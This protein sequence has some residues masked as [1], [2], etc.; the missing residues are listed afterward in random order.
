MCC[1]LFLHRMNNLVTFVLYAYSL[2]SVEHNWNCLDFLDMFQTWRRT[3]EHKNLV[4]LLL[5]IDLFDLIKYSVFQQVYSADTIIYLQSALV[6][7]WAFKNL[8]T[9]ET[10]LLVFS[11]FEPIHCVSLYLQ[12]WETYSNNPFFPHFYISVIVFKLLTFNACQDVSW[13]A[14]SFLLK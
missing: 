5:T 12:T 2:C 3:Q 11:F 14:P 10:E 8:S 6:K 1:S 4:Q 7:Y 13:T 9:K